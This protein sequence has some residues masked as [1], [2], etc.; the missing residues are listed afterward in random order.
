M[1]EEVK[2]VLPGRFTVDHIAGIMVGDL[3]IAKTNLQELEITKA[4]NDHAR[5]KIVAMIDDGEKPQWQRVTGLDIT[6]KITT[7]DGKNL[8]FGIATHYAV[9]E[10]V[11]KKREQVRGD[12][13]GRLNDPPIGHIP[14]EAFIYG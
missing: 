6:I 3:P 12:G 8:F 11:D 14:E 2:P 1:P 13:G 10:L 4:I 5:I 7:I 9:G